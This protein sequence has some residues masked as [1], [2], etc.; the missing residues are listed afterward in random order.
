MRS[1]PL[2]FVSSTSDLEQ[3]RREIA[4]SLRHSFDPYLYEEDRAR[5]TSPR[6][7][8]RKVIKQSE[9]FVGIVGSRYGSSVDEGGGRSICEWEFEVA[10][11]CG[12][13]E[14]MMMLSRADRA[15]G[16]EPKQQ[17]F[18]DSISEFGRGVW[19]GFFSTTHELVE[20]VKQAL[21]TWLVEFFCQSEER[22][23]DRRRRTQWVAI[24][25]AVAAVLIVI[26]AVAMNI[27]LAWFTAAQL[28]GI[29]AA[30]FAMI[31]LGFLVIV[32]AR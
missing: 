10:K 14:I 6:E 13:I 7:H 5:G 18:R 24:P 31:L 16:V 12:D 20:S 29:C 11:E 8:C 1:R 23:A 15:T 17:R 2:V 25:V 9:V 3:A 4:E 22:Q 30:S 26:G 32:A 21:T 28:L 27:T 19:C